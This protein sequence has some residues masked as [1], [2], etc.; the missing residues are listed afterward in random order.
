MRPVLCCPKAQESLLICSLPPI[1][2][3]V[4]LETFPIP[5]MTPSQ[6]PSIISGRTLTVRLLPILVGQLPNTYRRSSPKSSSGPAT[7]SPV[8]SVVWIHVRKC[9]LFGSYPHFRW[10]RQEQE[11]SGAI[12]FRGQEI[13]LK[14]RLSAISLPTSGPSA[15]TWTTK[16]KSNFS[17]IISPGKVDFGGKVVNQR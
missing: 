5:T 14:S 8:C 4:T 1:S 10:R 2:T 6:L 11:I 3:S 13:P 12:I 16:G 7:W 15:W 9:A 17:T